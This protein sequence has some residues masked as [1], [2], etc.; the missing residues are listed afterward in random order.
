LIQE[1]LIFM[2]NERKR[3]NAEVLGIAATR[4]NVNETQIRVGFSTDWCTLFAVSV[5]C[6]PFVPFGCVIEKLAQGAVY[7]RFFG[8]CT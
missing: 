2:A 6:R 3:P 7:R 8:R 4:R 5:L 1:T